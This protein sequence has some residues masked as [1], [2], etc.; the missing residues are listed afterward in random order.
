MMMPRQISA[1]RRK[2]AP[3]H[4]GEA[5]T[6]RHAG[7]KAA[8]SVLIA[9]W[10]FANSAHAQTTNF[11]FWPQIDTYISLTPDVDVMLLAAGSTDG[12]ATNQHVA[13]GPNIDIAVL[14]F[15]DPHLKTLNPEKKKFLTFRAGYRYID[16]IS[17]SGS[18]ENRGLLELTPRFPLPARFQISD[19]NRIDLRGLPRQ[20]TWRY[21]N[22]VQL[23]RSFQV[24][25]FIFTP[26]ASTEVFYDCKTGNWTRYNYA[27]GTTYRVTQKMQLEPYYQHGIPIVRTG[28]EARAIGLKLELFFR[29][30]TTP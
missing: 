8:I 25:E 17:G 30:Q 1:T 18:W 2:P 9:V 27:F 10:I 11:Q 20:F 7:V 16:T 29:Q 26:Y 13:F 28:K 6:G 4:L 21:R 5:V 19:E 12:D 3:C 15:L 23:G 22:K 24:R 14:P